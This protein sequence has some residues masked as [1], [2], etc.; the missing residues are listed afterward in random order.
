MKLEYIIKNDNLEFNLAFMKKFLTQERVK[1]LLDRNYSETLQHIS[2]LVKD[3]YEKIGNTLELQNDILQKIFLNPQFD[4][5]NLFKISPELYYLSQYLNLMD[6][7]YGI[8]SISSQDEINFMAKAGIPLNPQKISGKK[9]CLNDFD[10]NHVVISGNFDDVRISS[11]N[12]E[13][14]KG[15]VIN[16]QTVYAKNFFMTNLKDAIVVDNFCNINTCYTT[17]EGAR[18]INE[19]QYYDWCSINQFSNNEKKLQYFDKLWEESK[20]YTKKRKRS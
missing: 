14:S 8:I 18:L 2:F 3:E 13:G 4:N 17:F 20:P 9:Y 1:F 11:V 10:L 7:D 6:F 15:A 12:F 19:E 16:P 5:V